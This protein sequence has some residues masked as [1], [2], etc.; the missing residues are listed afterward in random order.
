[1]AVTA[2]PII[3]VDSASGSDTAAS[4]AGPAT[5]LTGSAASTDPG[6]TVVTLDGSPDLSGVNTDGSH[7]IFL[8]NASGRKFAAINAKG[9]N[10]V[11]VE[12]AF[13]G[14]Q[15]SLS[16]AI[17]GVRATVFGTDSFRLLQLSPESSGGWVVEMQSGHTESNTSSRAIYATND[18]T[19][20]LFTLRGESGAAT[21]PVVTTTNYFRHYANGFVYKDFE[22]KTDASP[23]LET[24]FS[25]NNSIV[26]DGMR[27]TKGTTAA[28]YI[29]VGSQSIVRNCL[30][31]QGTNAA[32]ATYNVTFQN[33]TFYKCTLG[34]LFSH[35][36]GT[37][38]SDCLFIEC[39]TGFEQNSSNE[40]GNISINRCVFD[41]CG[42]ALKLASQ[43]LSGAIHS[44]QFTN[45]TSYNIDCTHANSENEDFKGKLIASVYNNNHYN[46]TSGDVRLNG[47]NYNG[48][49]G[50]DS[51][52]PYN[53]SVYATR[54]TNDDWSVSTSAK[55]LGYPDAAAPDKSTR[56]YVDQGP[57]RQE[58]AGG[59]GG[60][61]KIAGGGGGIAG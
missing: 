18:A 49:L 22:I 46:Y 56:W 34:V 47:T 20:G 3:K 48:L 61:C 25:S 9:A 44:N 33:C 52:Q 41:K 21:V 1:M 26:V 11:T 23:A 24:I 4:G 54:D 8:S 35:Y 28:E 27:F 30:F 15:S 51:Y 39:T 60:G 38:V 19:G 17:G 58:P 42:T 6:G 12:Q 37:T 7:V 40:T 14:S 59:G 55:E 31:D 10:T 36:Y 2:W 29:I 57:Q 5:A 45:S 32:Q 16:W 50:A 53:E 13:T 43:K